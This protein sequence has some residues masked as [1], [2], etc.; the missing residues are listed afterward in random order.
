MKLVFITRKVDRGDPLTGFV[1]GWLNALAGRLDKL[2]VVC[3]EKGD[4]SGLA[5][6][7]EVHSFGKEKG[8]GR[9]RQAFELWNLSFEFGKKSEGFFIHMHPIYAITAWLPAKLFG[10]KIILWYAHKSVDF[11]LRVAH[12]L[13]DRVLT[14]SKESFRL[15]SNKVRV[16]GH[17]IDMRK[18][19]PSSH[20]PHSIFHILSIGRISPVKD[21]ETLIKAMEILCN[22]MGMRGLKV[23]IYGRIGLPE[24]QAYLDSL[25]DFVQNANLD[26]VIDFQSEVSHEYVPQILG[27]ADLFVNLSQT[28]SLDKAVLE[29]AAMGVLVL[30]SNEAF[31]SKLKEIS[32]LLFFKRNDPSDLAEKIM[33]TK[34]LTSEEKMKIA[35]Q[36]KSWVEREHNLNN[37]ISLIIKEFRQV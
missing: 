2:Y 37:L 32:P 13:V 16:V 36:L 17:G 7:I 35:N 15:P 8:Y 10:K 11:K 6:N 30:T 12:F 33:A 9:L 29:A 1:F 23:Q 14:S 20:I 22:D 19:N 26:E 3:Q 18:F 28:G 34:N 4:T 21:Y 5:D 27:E 31:E 24:H 25:V